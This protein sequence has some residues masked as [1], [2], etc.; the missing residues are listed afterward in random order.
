VK[1]GRKTVLKLSAKDKRKQFL[2]G[3]F[4]KVSELSP[5]FHISNA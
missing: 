2:E 3:L 4:Q 1:S 5:P